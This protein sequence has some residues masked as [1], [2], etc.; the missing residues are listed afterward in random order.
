[1]HHKNNH[2]PPP[3]TPTSGCSK[4]PG[5]GFLADPEGSLLRGCQETC[6]D[7]GKGTSWD[8]ACSWVQNVLFS[9]EK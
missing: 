9:G 2:G 7:V 3:P 5:A 4:N 6:G 1:M 8:W